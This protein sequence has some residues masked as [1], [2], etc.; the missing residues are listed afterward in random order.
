MPK[1]VRKPLEIKDF[2]EGIRELRSSYKGVRR[3][4]LT[5]IGISYPVEIA[6]K[7]GVLKGWPS[8]T[9]FKR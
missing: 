4:I 8:S 3:V 6:L 5:R 9:S 2:D 7:D 1:N